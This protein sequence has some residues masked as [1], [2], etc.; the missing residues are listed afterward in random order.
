M[1]STAA[2]E[3]SDGSGG[4]LR[5]LRTVPNLVSISRVGL[6]YVALYFWYTGRPVI[7]L[8]I[9]VVAGLSDYLD[10]YLARRMNQSTRIGGLIDQACDIIFITGC[11][12]IFVRDGT[13]PGALL[14]IVL[15]RETVVLNLRA[16]AAEMGFSLPSI[17]L[18]K[19]ASNFLFWSLATMGLSKCL[20]ESLAIYPRYLAHFGVTVGT[21]LSLVTGTIYLRSYARRYKPLPSAQASSATDVSERRRDE[22]ADGAASDNR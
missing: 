8:P 17:L 16:S 13:W 4:L 14:Y 2:R 21:V 9:G 10:G 20:P 12:I 7:G 19:V 1:A 15:F 3:A 6:I 11:I 18:G 22:R 5:D